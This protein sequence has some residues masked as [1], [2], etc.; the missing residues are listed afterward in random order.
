MPTAR[1]RSKGQLTLPS[2]IREAAQLKEGDCVEVLLHPADIL[3]LQRERIDPDQA[4]FWTPEWQAGEREADAD[5]A[6]GRT[7]C[8]NTGEELLAAL[9]S[10]ERES[11]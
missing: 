2:E 4:W 11:E 3:L 5:I 7:R 8:F 6:A 9:E 10:V 1:L